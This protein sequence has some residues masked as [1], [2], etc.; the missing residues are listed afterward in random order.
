LKGK[1]PEP[2]ESFSNIFFLFNGQVSQTSTVVNIDAP[3]LGLG[4]PDLGRLL[5]PD[6]DAAYFLLSA[7]PVSQQ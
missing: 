7:P 3:L 1:L 2:F 6:F 5:P 4:F